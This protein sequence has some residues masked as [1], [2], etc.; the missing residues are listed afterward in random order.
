MQTHIKKPITISA[1]SYLNTKPFIYGLQHTDIS[2]KIN[3]Q[4]DI[5]SQCATK[6]INKDVDIALVPIAALVKLKKYHIISNYCIGA[7]GKVDT[8]SLFSDVPF[9]ETTS[10]LLD[11][12]SMTSQQLLKILCREFWKVNPQFV[13]T[14]EGY[15]SDIKDKVAGLVIGDRVFKLKGRFKYEY[16]LSQLWTE[17]TGLPFVF[18]VW[19]S[20]KTLS[21]SFLSKFNSALKYGIDNI[22]KVLPLI[23]NQNNFNA[24]QYLTS[25]IDYS[26]DEPK[27]K[28]LDLF[29]NKIT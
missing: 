8:V 1:V 19:V 18:A 12:Q 26:L 15:I 24:E 14:K 5:P 21:S 13:N 29:L 23:N 9:N 4:L 20:T 10:I 27:R 28:A 22:N 25:S 7:N 3:L 16:D 2:E 17:L 6:L 11:F